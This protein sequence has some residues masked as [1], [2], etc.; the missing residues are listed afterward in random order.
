[1]DRITTNKQ[2]LAFAKVCIEVDASTEIPKSIEA[3]M[4]NGF[5]I[6]ISMVIPWLPQKCS[7]CNIFGHLDKNCLKKKS[8]PNTKVWIPKFHFKATKDGLRNIVEKK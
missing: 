7:Q 6:S 4:R 1:M 5:V 2:H 3:K 8:V